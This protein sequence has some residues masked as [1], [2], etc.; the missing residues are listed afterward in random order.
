MSYYVLAK[1]AFTVA[2]LVDTADEWRI[3]CPI[4][5]FLHASSM[6]RGT[7]ASCRGFKAI[8]GRYAENGPSSLTSAMM[9]ETNKA[10]SILEL[11]KVDLR[12][13]GFI[14]GGT[15]YLTNGYLKKA[16]KADV[17]EVVKAI[18]AKNEFLSRSR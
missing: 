13:L 8:L 9:H 15:L 3:T 2:A 11:I 5:E 16:Q 7:A 18:K 12:L 1:D 10:N 6:N 17:A 14:E 4:L